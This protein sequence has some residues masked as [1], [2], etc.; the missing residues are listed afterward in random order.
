MFWTRRLSRGINNADTLAEC[1]AR[2]IRVSLRRRLLRRC[3]NTMPQKNLSPS[4]RFQNVRGAF[5]AKAS[6]QLKGKRI[7]LVDDTLT[8]GATCSEAAR[9]L[10]QAGAAVVACAVVA[11][12][13]GPGAT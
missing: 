11:R 3:R 9:T 1:L 2:E 6:P 4:A 13:H 5:A 7:L 10:K 8:T 12:A